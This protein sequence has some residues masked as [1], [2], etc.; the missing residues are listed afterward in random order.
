MLFA[1]TS[2]AELFPP[3]HPELACLK[4]RVLS[5]VAEL[6]MCVHAPPTPADQSDKPASQ[7]GRWKVLL[8]LRETCSLCLCRGM[9]FV[10]NPEDS[11]KGISELYFTICS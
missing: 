8:G 11:E 4:I 3:G 9:T 1:T 10:F 5:R 2:A 7:F 6:Q